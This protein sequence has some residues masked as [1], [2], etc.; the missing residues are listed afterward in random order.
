MDDCLAALMREFSEEPYARTFGIEIIELEAGHAILKMKTSEMMNNLFGATHGAAIFS[1]VD[2][3]FELTVNSHGTVA[4]ALSVNMNY[5][6]APIPGE[7]LQSE[8]REINRSRRISACQISVTGEDGRPIA[9]CQ[10]LA[11]RKK[12]QLPFL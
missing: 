4:V 5:L 1:L 2:A 10:C 12:D 7:C 3:T 6:N 9:T 11:Y 8:G